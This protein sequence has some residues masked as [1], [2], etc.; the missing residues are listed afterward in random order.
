MTV[1]FQE[2]ERH[3]R[4][5]VCPKLPRL[6][7]AL[8]F[9][10]REM[11]AFL[12][13]RAAPS[14]CMVALA[15]RGAT[16]GASFMATVQRATRNW[17]VWLLVA[18]AFGAACGGNAFHVDAE[19]AAGGGSGSG[20]EPGGAGST[21][22]AGAPSTAGKSSQGGT[23]G[24]IGGR[25]GAPA[26][27]GSTP[28]AGALPTSGGEG[29]NGSDPEVLPISQ[30]QLVYWF[31][32]DA[33][34][35]EEAG[36]ISEWEDQSGNAQHA[37]QGLPSQQPRLTSND[38]L[39]HPVV[40]LNGATFLELPA[41]D[42]PIDGGLTFFAVAG[43]SNVSGCSAI[44]ELSNG[45]EMDDVHFGH[46]GP[47]MHYEVANTWFDGESDVFEENTMRQLTY[48]QLGDDVGAESE[49]SA[50][51]SLVG[52]GA[53]PFAERKRRSENFIGFSLYESCTKFIGGIGEV[54]LYSRVLGDEEQRAVEQYLLEKWQLD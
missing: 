4:V 20:D 45:R 16:M 9:R 44:V 38:L 3:D 15:V 12:R 29:G 42:V 46:G 25:G 26:D 21:A 6:V 32:A 24:G 41:I 39:P 23:R 8:H 13:A 33:G 7:Q 30:D 22:K 5:D 43:L 35:H 14:G 36:R 34:V 28:Q 49:L 37:F 51:G 27:G 1:R 40:E 11:T 54:I 17:A 53:V 47:R 18:V 50:N 10:A 31:K 52:R 19:G 2:L 48:K